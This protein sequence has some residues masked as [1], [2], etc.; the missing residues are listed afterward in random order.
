MITN[1]DDCY[2]INLHG[3]GRTVT[4]SRVFLSILEEFSSQLQ[5]AQR[6]PTNYCIESFEGKVWLKMWPRLRKKIVI[7]GWTSYF[8]PLVMTDLTGSGQL[9]KNSSLFHPRGGPWT[10]H[11]WGRCGP[12][13]HWQGRRCPPAE[14]E[15]T[16]ATTTPAAVVD[17]GKRRP[18]RSSSI[19]TLGC[20]FQSVRGGWRWR[21]GRTSSITRRGTTP[22][23]SAVG[24]KTHLSSL[25][26]WQ[27]RRDTPAVLNY[28]QK[29]QIDH[30]VTVL[31]TLTWQMRPWFSSS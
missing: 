1:G 9:F 15:S 13:A 5:T 11:P 27:Q 7:S 6:Y 25:S 23:P 20:R 24:S 26:T 10:H 14:S 12:G 4:T 22:S 17:L 28:H 21:G 30:L 2:W 8:P 16:T 31:N 18:G 19:L 3:L 29:L